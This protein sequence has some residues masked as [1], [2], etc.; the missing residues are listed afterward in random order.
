MT[1]NRRRSPSQESLPLGIGALP[2]GVVHARPTRRTVGL[3]MPIETRLELHL[4]STR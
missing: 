3:S 1:G 4:G 2:N